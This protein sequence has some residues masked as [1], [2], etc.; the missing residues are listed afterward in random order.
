MQPAGSSVR[1][2]CVGVASDEIQATTAMNVTTKLEA[3]ISNVYSGSSVVVS[4]SFHI[5]VKYS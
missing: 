5:N 4:N 3:M 2:E 1:N